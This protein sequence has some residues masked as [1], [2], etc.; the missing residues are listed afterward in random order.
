MM[1]LRERSRDTEIR[2]RRGCVLLIRRPRARISARVSRDQR[3]QARNS[4]WHDHAATVKVLDQ[5]PQ[6]LLPMFGYDTVHC[7]IQRSRRTRRRTGS[8][9]SKFG[10]QRIGGKVFTCRLWQARP[11]CCSCS[12][13]C[14]F[15]GQN[16]H[17]ANR[18]VEN[19]S[20]VRFGNEKGLHRG[21][22]RRQQSFAASAL[23]GFKRWHEHLDTKAGNQAAT[24]SAG[25]IHTV[26]RVQMRRAAAN[27]PCCPWLGASGALRA[28]RARTKLRS[29]PGTVAAPQT[30]GVLD[31]TLARLGHRRRSRHLDQVGAPR[32]SASRKSSL[33]LGPTARSAPT[34]LQCHPKSR[35]L[36]LIH[37]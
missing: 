33:P 9:Q 1:C 25:C 21:R 2:P 26:Q 17:R 29:W 19:R 12:C 37:I 5:R 16:V 20:Q 31:P 13:T 14:A 7:I 27:L 22:G 3:M 8:R 4:A 24:L 35:D 32:Q 18:V 30:Y 36:S 15:R 10:S 34:R 23:C 28:K 6:R 11:C